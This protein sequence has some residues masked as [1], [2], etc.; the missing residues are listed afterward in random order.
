MPGKV[1]ADMNEPRSSSLRRNFVV[2]VI[3]VLSG[4]IAFGQFQHLGWP[5]EDYDSYLH[6]AAFAT[7][8]LLAAIAWPRAW[9]RLLFV[10]LAI[11]AGATELLQF[12]PGISRTP[13]WSDF[14]FNICGIAVMLGVV[15]ALRAKFRS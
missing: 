10:G 5:I 4:F 3:L 13:S 11:L 2:A 12:T 9:F 6:F 14:G 8:S 1:P 15:A 7:I